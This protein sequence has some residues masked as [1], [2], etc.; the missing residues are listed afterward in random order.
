MLG[1]FYPL[2]LNEP[3]TTR[4]PTPVITT[5]TVKNSQEVT[6]DK[7]GLTVTS[8]SLSDKM[9]DRGNV[10]SLVVPTAA[11]TGSK[12]MIDNVLNTSSRISESNMDIATT[13]G[14]FAGVSFLFDYMW[15]M[16]GM[17]NM[18]MEGTCS[19]CMTRNVAI[20]VSE[21]IY[22]YYKYRMFPNI[23]VILSEVVAIM[24]AELTEKNIRPPMLS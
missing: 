15:T 22:D 12:Y 17:T 19:K 3:R 9:C 14:I 8:S 7:I 2:D 18:K 6:E 10:K 23:T 5:V 24:V 13:A 16:K 20:L 21:L 4:M 1:P 11:Y